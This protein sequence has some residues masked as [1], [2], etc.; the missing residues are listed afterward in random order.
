MEQLICPCYFKVPVWCGS[1]GKRALH[2]A[3]FNKRIGVFGIVGHMGVWR[4]VEGR[5][6]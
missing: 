4:S 3:E 2:P 1:S 5:T 6:V